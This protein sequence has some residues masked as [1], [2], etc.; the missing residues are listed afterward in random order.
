MKLRKKDRA[1]LEIILDEL[2]R[3]I[4]YVMDDRTAL[5]RKHN[6]SSA[7]YFESNYPDYRGQKWSPIEKRAGN[8]FVIAI[9][10][11]NR[12][13]LLLKQDEN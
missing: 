10:A 13:E 6:L 9:S 8:D 1:K 4:N 2:K 5:M 7:D 12:L 3:G 11:T